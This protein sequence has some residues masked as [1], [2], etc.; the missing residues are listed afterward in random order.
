M[1]SKPQAKA[2]PN[3]ETA[4]IDTFDLERDSRCLY[5]SRRTVS[6]AVATIVSKIPKNIPCA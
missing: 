1:R 3:D 5:C 4:Q 2:T 6:A